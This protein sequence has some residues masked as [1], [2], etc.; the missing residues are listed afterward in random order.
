MKKNVIL[1]ITGSNEPSIVRPLEFLRAKGLRVFR[2]NIDKL[3]EKG[4]FEFYIGYRKRTW[5]IL[6]DGE[7][8]LSEQVKSIWYRRPP[9][10]E[11][12]SSSARGSKRFIREETKKALWALWTAGNEKILWMNHPL[13]SKVLEF[14]KP[15][16]MLVASRVGL[17]I[18]KT[19]IG[20][21]PE[22]ALEFVK[23]CGGE[24][25]IKVFGSPGLRDVKGRDLVV[26][27]NRISSKHIMKHGKEISCCPVMLENYVPKEF[28]LRVT[29]VG[30]LIFPCAIHSQNSKK[31]KDDWRRYDLKNVE[32]ESCKLPLD[33]EN[34]IRKLM[35][36]FK[37]NFGAIDMIVTPDKEFVFLE[38]NPNGQWGW[39]EK[40]TGMPISKAIAE[41][42]CR[43]EKSCYMGKFF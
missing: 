36:A 7:E 8:V 21:I 35:K 30:N 40:L 12:P 42:L 27:T 38:I 14:N 32:H 39:I 2:V 1:I 22:K 5:S 4:G 33:V 13:T 16:Q 31:T 10:P 34:K 19:F 3:L 43:K 25:I 6:Y 11:A 15:Y 28:E 29:V 20:N 37:L 26:F 9:H 17:K 41:V 18:P 23:R 24:G